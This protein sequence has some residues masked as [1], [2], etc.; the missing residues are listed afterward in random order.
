ESYVFCKNEVDN[1]WNVVSK[2][3]LDDGLPKVQQMRNA[4]KYV[5]KAIVLKLLPG[6]EQKYTSYITSICRHEPLKK[7]LSL[8]AHFAHDMQTIRR[9]IL[10]VQDG[11]RS[12][13]GKRNKRIYCRARNPPLMQTILNQ[14]HP[15][16]MMTIRHIKIPFTRK[17]SKNNT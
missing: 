13:T 17:S 5:R 11:N 15:L 12:E 6:I 10:S 4:L 2:W 7:L 14:Q 3:F 9:F 16:Q 8:K 1:S